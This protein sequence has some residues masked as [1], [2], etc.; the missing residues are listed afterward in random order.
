LNPAELV[1]PI[2]TQVLLSNEPM[3]FTVNPVGEPVVLTCHVTTEG[4]EPPE[5]SILNEVH[6]PAVP[7]LLLVAVATAEHDTPIIPAD[8]LDV[9]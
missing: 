3:K 4:T 7:G 6:P 2:C 1:V 8:K 5:E 9:V